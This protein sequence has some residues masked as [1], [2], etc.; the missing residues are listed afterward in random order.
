MDIYVGN[1]AYT[2]SD[3]SLKVAF[4][5]YGEVTSARVVSDRMTGRSKGF[6]FV[7]MPDRTQAQAAI[8][9]LNGKELDGRTIRVNESQPKPRE[10]RGGG[11]RGG[12]GGGGGFR[13]GSGRGGAG[14]RGGER[15][16]SRW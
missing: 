1:L 16:E 8:D 11:F 13:G 7:E 15:R 6:G 2:T 5:A 14:G 4:E 10:E 3:E 12:A 9:A